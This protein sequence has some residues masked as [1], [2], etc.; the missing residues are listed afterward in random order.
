MSGYLDNVAG[1]LPHV[2]YYALS[3]SDYEQVKMRYDDRI[4][5]TMFDGDPHSDIELS[6]ALTN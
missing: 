5:G 2:Y 3:D 4:T 6:S 1:I